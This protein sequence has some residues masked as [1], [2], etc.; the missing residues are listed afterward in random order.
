MTDLK[1]LKNLMA[2]VMIE[3][4]RRHM[5]VETLRKALQRRPTALEILYYENELWER[6]L[7]QWQQDRLKTYQKIHDLVWG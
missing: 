6:E 7:S 4:M 3:A 1:P 5:A 2:S